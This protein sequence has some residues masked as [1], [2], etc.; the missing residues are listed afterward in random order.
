MFNTSASS[1]TNGSVFVVGTARLMA[2]ATSRPDH[3]SS[4]TSFCLKISL[5]YKGRRRKGVETNV[6]DLLERLVVRGRRNGRTIYLYFEKGGIELQDQRNSVQNSGG[7]SS[8][9]FSTTSSA[10]W[11]A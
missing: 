4:S 3:E 2:V 5:T 9:T 11:T 1:G 6:S 10:S 7:R 8:I